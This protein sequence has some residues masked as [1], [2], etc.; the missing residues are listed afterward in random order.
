MHVQVNAVFVCRR[1]LKHAVFVMLQA[2]T[3][4]GLHIDSASVLTAG[5]GTSFCSSRSLLFRDVC[6]FSARPQAE[7]Q[8]GRFTTAWRQ[9]KVTTVVAGLPFNVGAIV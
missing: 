2:A 1:R 6:L 5:F 3:V 9:S 8:S 4:K 7:P